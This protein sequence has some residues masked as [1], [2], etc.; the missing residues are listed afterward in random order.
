M[1]EVNSQAQAKETIPETTQVD[2]MLW[3]LLTIQFV[4]DTSSRTGST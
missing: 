3:W 1:R 2:T 4:G